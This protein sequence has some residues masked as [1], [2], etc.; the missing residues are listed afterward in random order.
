MQSHGPSSHFVLLEFLPNGLDLDFGFNSAKSE[1]G[2][3]LLDSMT[4]VRVLAG[5]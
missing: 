4:I 5:G 2:A 3:D 1:V